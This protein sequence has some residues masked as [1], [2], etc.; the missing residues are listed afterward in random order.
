ML[1]IRYGQSSNL[2]RIVPEPQSDGLAPVGR[3]LEFSRARIIERTTLQGQTL[4]GGR[5][6]GVNVASIS[7]AE[8][9]LRLDVEPH[10]LGYL[11]A[12]VF[13]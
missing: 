7:T 11:G 9:T 5:R 13:G 12:E 4:D 2:C 1:E 3:P 10:G 8:I 6:Q